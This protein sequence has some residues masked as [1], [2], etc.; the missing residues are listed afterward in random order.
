LPGLNT[1]TLAA[2]A[3]TTC[4]QLRKR[5]L[6]HLDSWG[7]R[8]R[9]IWD[10]NDVFAGVNLKP[11]VAWSHD[12]DGYSPG[13]GGNFEEGRKAVSLG[14]DAEYQNTY[15][16]S[17]SYTNFFDGKYTTVDDRDFVALSFGVNF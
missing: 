5:R 8:A 11:N 7:Y 13:P 16:A 6:H 12:V 3:R 2:A 14:L 4:P 17:L 15:T 1:S 9:A 10:Y